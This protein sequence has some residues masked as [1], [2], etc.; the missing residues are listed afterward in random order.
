MV[1][2]APPGLLPVATDLA[3]ASIEGG[4][5]TPVN[6]YAGFT[7][8]GMERFAA[9]ATPRTSRNSPKAPAV[10]PAPL[11]SLSGPGSRLSPRERQDAG[12][13]WQT[14]CMHDWLHKHSLVNVSQR[15]I[16]QAR[17]EGLY[18]CFQMMDTDN[19]GTIDNFE[20]NTA[21]KARRCPLETPPRAPAAAPALPPAHLRPVLP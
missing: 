7:T 2:V 4:Y 18:D 5:S 8:P 6:P 12:R 9:R 13:K 16:S 20:L 10:P 15:E 11:Y 1:M 14:A 3:G 21:M 19:S 17:R